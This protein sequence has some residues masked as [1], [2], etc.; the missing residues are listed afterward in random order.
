MD[1][2]EEESPRIQRKPKPSEADVEPEPEPESEEDLDAY[3]PSFIDDTEVVDETSYNDTQPALAPKAF[4]KQKALLLSDEEE[5]T[6]KPA[7]KKPKKLKKLKEKRDVHWAVLELE[8][9][10]LDA[11]PARCDA[12]TM[13]DP[14]E[15]KVGVWCPQWGQ[16]FNFSQ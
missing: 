6:P 5:E 14:I 9:K 8:K 13:T 15:F 12:S 1:E 3:E 11:R 10:L 7:P 4:K 2:A 16:F